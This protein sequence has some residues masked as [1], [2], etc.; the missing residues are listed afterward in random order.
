[1]RKTEITEEDRNIEMFAKVLHWICDHAVAA[2]TK[3][4]NLNAAWGQEN[5]YIPSIEWEKYE[6]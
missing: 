6:T 1:M 4:N 3:A 5:L 2:E